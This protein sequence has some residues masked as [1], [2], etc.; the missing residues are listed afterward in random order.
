MRI[1]S[2]SV[3]PVSFNDKLSITDSLPITPSLRSEPLIP[4]QA[5]NDTGALNKNPTSEAELEQA[6]KSI[7][8]V[9]ETANVSLKFRRD[10]S[11]GQ[12][13]VELV[14]QTSGDTLRQIPSEALLRISAS[15]R[16]LQGLVVDRQI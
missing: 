11:S 3:S 2:S 8:E 15:L 7:N 10:D 1:E 13:I 4:E 6:L 14:D 9:T 5:R 16:K 12:T